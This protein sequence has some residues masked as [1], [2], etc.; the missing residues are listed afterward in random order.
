M[1][2]NQR[3]FNSVVVLTLFAMLF[4]QA[5]LALACGPFTLSAVFTF[6]VHPEYPLESYAKG[7]IGV[8]QP[9]YARSY[10][11]AAYRHLAGVGFNKTE[12]EALVKLWRDRLEFRFENGENLTAPWI[13][14]RKKVPN[15]AELGDLY[16]YRNRE[17]PNEYEQYLNCAGD[18]FQTAATTLNARIEKFGAE[19]PVIRDWVNAQDQV[20]AN[21]SSGTN[22]PAPVPPESDILIRN[23]RA[24]QIAAANFY[25]GNYGEAKG[26]FAA[27]AHDK[28][29]SWQPSA[30]YLLARTFAREASLGPAEGRDEAHAAA[31][32]ELNAILKNPGMRE[33]HAAARRLLNLVLLRYRPEERLGQLA[34]A[35]LLK[36]NDNL[37]QELWDYT[38][39]L[40]QF[41]GDDWPEKK[42]AP[43]AARKDDLSDWITT[44]Q[45][46]SPDSSAH[47]QEK[48]RASRSLPWLVAALSKASSSNTQQELLLA[49]NK[50]T[51]DSPGFAT[52]SF[53]LVRLMIEGK[54]FVEARA[55]LDDLLLKY[56]SRFTVSGTN[57]LESHRLL[58]AT[59]LQDFLKHAKR[60]PAAFSWDDDGRQVPASESETPDETKALRG[61]LLL[62][63]DVAQLLNKDFP[64]EL[65]RE[66]AESE[67]LPTNLKRDV[68]QA[69]WLRAVLLGDAKTAEALV[70]TLRAQIPQLGTL[71]DEYLAAK[72]ADAR[73]FSAIYLWLKFPG[74][75]PVVDAGIGR[76][77]GPGE[78]DSYRDNWWCTAAFPPSSEAQ[79]ADAAR[80]KPVFLTT[81]QQAAGK[82]EATKLQALGAAPN[83]L[84]REVIQWA[85]K[86]PGDPRLPEALHLAVKS[87]RFGCTDTASARWSKA[88]FDLL[89][90]RYPRNAWTKKTP[91]WFKD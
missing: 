86:T 22:I 33:W 43:A 10:L 32:K 72:Q 61:K 58:V 21:C 42:E 76:Q 60:I 17:K 36:S 65:W 52:V 34:S 59:D 49:A 78:Q 6:T 71:L 62:D 56:R 18:A 84:A 91:Y 64:L 79:Q 85:N 63:S 31:E 88:A 82:A 83:L 26:L 53:H 77:I 19:S 80:P 69:A 38:L 12:Q 1:K 48:W 39:L 57:Q 55:K 20:F 66:A 75:E 13:A 2:N 9:T 67:V 46:D 89:H 74:L 27:I 70:P 51:A 16:V 14:A 30:S 90:R 41:L 23:D 4:M 28:T 7:D 25:A 3:L 37:H 8:V 5:P 54:Q 50:V 44:F 73:K 24:Y 68:V 87:T 29:S 45:Q 47:A 11:Y 40:D 15:T 81:Q 35:L